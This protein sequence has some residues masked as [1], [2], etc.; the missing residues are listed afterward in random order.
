MR[1]VFAAALALALAAT[2]VAACGCGGDASTA[3]SYMKK[4]D[5]LLKTVETSYT[6]ISEKTTTLLTDYTAGKNTEPAG[7]AASVTEIKALLDK[8][9]TGETAAKAEYG[10]MLSLKG[11]PD[12]VKYAALQIEVIDK[13]D[14]ANDDVRA[15]LDLVQ[16]SS[17]SGQPPD[18]QKLTALSTSIQTLSNEIDSLMKKASDLKKSKNLG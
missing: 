17:T 18:V 15:M 8:A 6:S 5:A 2:I 7:V 11:V 12:Y 16:V 4:A 1:K 9:K 14:K 13:L 3:K 10:K